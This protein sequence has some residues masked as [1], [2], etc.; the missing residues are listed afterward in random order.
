MYFQYLSSI[1]YHTVKWSFIPMSKLGKGAWLYSRF[2]RTA[3]QERSRCLPYTVS[4]AM[5]SKS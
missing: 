5:L 1:I 4:F 3:V 2:G